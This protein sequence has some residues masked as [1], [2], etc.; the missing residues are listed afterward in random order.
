MYS[1]KMYS[2]IAH[3]T[4]ESKHY[5]SDKVVFEKKSNELQLVQIALDMLKLNL[6][7]LQKSIQL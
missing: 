1:T 6:K 2:V 4:D 5:K 3:V 7:I